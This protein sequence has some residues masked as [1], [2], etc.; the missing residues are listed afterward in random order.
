MTIFRAVFIPNKYLVLGRSN[1]DRKDLLSVM[2]NIQF[3]YNDYVPIERLVLSDGS[4]V[5]T[6]N[7]ND[8]VTM[9]ERRN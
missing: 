7:F 4:V 9:T 6:Y 2:N 3:N 8:M 1:Q 5:D